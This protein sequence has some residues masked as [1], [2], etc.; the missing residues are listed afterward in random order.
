MAS[1][2][3]NLIL[4]KRNNVSGV[5]PRLSSLELGELGINTV[6]GK[7]FTKTVSDSVSSIVSFLNS[8]D[9]PYTLNHYYSSVNF[10]YGNNTVNQ[11]YASVLGGYNNDITGGGSSVINGEDNDIAGDFSLIGSGLKN[12]INASGDYSFIAA[13]SGNLINHSNVFVLGS[14]LSSHASDFTYVNN[15]SATNTIFGDGS[16]ILNVSAP[17]VVALVSNAESTNLVRGNVVYAFG[18]HGDKLSVKLA[19]NTSESTSSKTLGIV[20]ETIPP[21]ETGYITIGGSMDGLALGSFNS[22]DS[23]WLGSTA[24]SFTN[25]KPIAPNHG[26]YLGVVERAN[27]GN[28][29]AFIKVQNGYELNEIHDVL[30][31]SVSAGDIIRRNSTNTLWENVSLSNITIDTGVRSLTGYY[32]SVYTTVQTNSAEWEA[33]YGSSGA[34]LLVR[35][36]TGFWDSTFTTVSSNSA[37]WNY[38]G[39]DLKELSGNWQTAYS[40]VSA[41]SVNLTANNIFVSNDLNVIDT[42]SAKYFQGTLLDW[43]TLVRGYKTTPTL[44]ATIGTGE[45]YSYVYETTGTD[46]TYYRYIAHGNVY[47]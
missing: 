11:V 43:M 38:Q 29:I 1:E 8:N 13:G 22:G 19:S 31:T 47:F 21:N 39:T 40:Y 17:N 7:L 36:L 44:L 32:D 18:S 3:E 37:N 6:D 2:T 20:N 28:G 23:L 46:V 45:V 41:N 25:I 15:I 4:I 27:N 9:Y 5:I 33:A 10:I 30:I 26:V 42:V 12:K 14:D 35:S 34:D 16:G 24:G